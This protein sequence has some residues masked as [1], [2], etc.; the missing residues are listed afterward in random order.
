M[1]NVIAA[2]MQD[3]ISPLLM[4]SHLAAIVLGKQGVAADMI[5]IDGAHDYRSV[6]MDLDAYAPL[7]ADGGIMLMDDYGWYES[8]TR[9]IREFASRNGWHLSAEQKGK[10]VLSWNEIPKVLIAQV[11][12]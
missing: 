6:S 9:A 11:V 4:P 2:G 7:L 10:A 12:S 8:T 1:K 3:M 5:Y